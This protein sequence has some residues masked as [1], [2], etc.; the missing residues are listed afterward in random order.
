MKTKI[1]LGAIVIN[2][3]VNIYDANASTWTKSDLSQARGFMASIAVG[4]KNYW[5]GGLYKQP[6]NPFTGRAEIRDEPKGLSTN[7]C[8]FQ[9]NAFFSAVLKGNKIV[10]FTSGVNIPGYWLHL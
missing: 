6:N 2:S 4:N 9:P 1:S 10:F 5:A 8:L 3:T 7:S